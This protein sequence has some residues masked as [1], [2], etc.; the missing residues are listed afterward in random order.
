MPRVVEDAHGGRTSSVRRSPQDDGPHAHP[1]TPERW[2]LKISLN[3]T[4]NSFIIKFNHVLTLTVGW[5]SICTS[6]VVPK[7]LVLYTFEKSL[8]RC[9][10]FHNADDNVD[11]Q[12]CWIGQSCFI[13]VF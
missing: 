1:Q 3:S 13:S 10:R 6:F 4:F 11:E 9:L 7:I 5:E 12:E 2:D 8:N